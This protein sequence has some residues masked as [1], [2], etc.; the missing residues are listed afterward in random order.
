[1]EVIRGVQIN[2]SNQ[3]YIDFLKNFLSLPEDKQKETLLD[4]YYF[5]VNDE[6][7]AVRDLPRENGDSVEKYHFLTNSL[8]KLREAGAY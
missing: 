8:K 7:R 6:T 3:G 1:M 5:A 2:E 4:L